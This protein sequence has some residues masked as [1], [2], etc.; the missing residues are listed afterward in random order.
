MIAAL[1]TLIVQNST[2][3]LT[4]RYSR[5]LPGT[6]YLGSTAVACDEAMKLV[7]CTLVLLGTYLCS[8]EEEVRCEVR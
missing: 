4:M 1:A 6:M 2:L 3:A 5:T 7:T 8:G